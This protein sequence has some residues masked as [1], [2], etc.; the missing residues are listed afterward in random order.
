MVSR[1]I[2]TTA[3]A[4]A[5]RRWWREAQEGCEGGAGPLRTAVIERKESHGGLSVCR[6]RQPPTVEGMLFAGSDRREPPSVFDRVRGRMGGSLLDR[7]CSGLV[8]GEGGKSGWEEA[9]KR[10]KRENWQGVA[11]AS[12]VGTTSEWVRL[13]RME[14]VDC[15]APW[16]PQSTRPVKQGLLKMGV[17]NFSPVV[18]ER[19][20][21]I[22]TDRLS[23]VGPVDPPRALL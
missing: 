2:L 12:A 18:E 23:P 17:L 16:V 14:S 20:D 6:R 21:K 9:E 7:L 11:V 5:R 4:S 15:G 8:S 3:S 10:Q 13:R 19:Q 1:D 22:P